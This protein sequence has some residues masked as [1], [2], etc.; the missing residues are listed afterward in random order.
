MGKAGARAV[1]K[2]VALFLAGIAVMM[3][4]SGVAEM[5]KGM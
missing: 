2:V 1:G 3:I 4:R 5:V